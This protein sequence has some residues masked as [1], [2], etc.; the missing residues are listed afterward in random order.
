MT[1]IRGLFDLSWSKLAH[2]RVRPRPILKCVSFLHLHMPIG[3]PRPPQVNAPV[4]ME[5]PEPAPTHMAV[6]IV[7]VQVRLLL[8]PGAGGREG[9]KKGRE[10]I[11][12]S[13]MDRVYLG[14]R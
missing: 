13:R 6:A 3:L 8:R 7:P 5:R 9:G 14:L 1:K 2:H 12:G 10:M 4:M 11:P